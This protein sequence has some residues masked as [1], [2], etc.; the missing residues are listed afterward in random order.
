MLAWVAQKQILKIRRA[1]G[2]NKLVRGEVMV[3][4]RDCH[5]NKLFRVA[6][7]FR[8]LEEALVVVLPLQHKVV[9]SLKQIF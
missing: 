5:V 1:H 9:K 7:V 2:Q 8:Q 6:E 3:P 4:A